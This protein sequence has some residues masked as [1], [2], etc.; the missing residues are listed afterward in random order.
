MKLSST[1]VA[2]AAALAGQTLAGKVSV[3]P[4][5]QVLNMLAEVKAKGTKMMDEE[6]G[7]FAKYAE[8]VDDQKAELGFN[9][10][11]A[12]SKI[13]ELVAFI[14]KAESDSAKAGR[15]VAALKAE[16][17][18]LSAERQSATR[19]RETEKAEYQKAST[20]LSES[21]D[22]LER[23]LQTLRTQASGDAE[24]ASMLQSMVAAKGMPRV[25][26][27]F[28]AERTA[29]AGASAQAASSSSSL[30]SDDEEGEPGAP[31]AAAYESQ[32][33]GVLE[34]L[35]GLLG[36][37]RSELENAEK[38]EVNQAHQ[39]ALT[40][41]HLS[42]AIARDQDEERT[43]KAL[44]G[45]HASASAKA[46]AELTET[47]RSKEAD[48]ALRAETMATFKA[49]SDAFQENQKTRKAELV[50]IDKATEILSSPAVA[51]SYA[52]HVNLAQ[53]ASRAVAPVA[54]ASKSSGSSRRNVAFLQLRSTH[55]QSLAASS[56]A[57]A[58]L[59]A[60]AQRLGSRTLARAASDMGGM[61]FDKVINMIEEMINKLK[62]DAAE[63][64]NHKSWC[65]EQLQANKEKRN[66]RSA[67]AERLEADVEGFEAD[68]ADKGDTIVQLS[69][70]Q[71]D[72]AKGMDEATSLRRVERAEHE[73]T[74]QDAASGS[75]AVHR[76]LVVLKEFYA[77]AGQASLLQQAPAMERYTGM[78]SG[79][80]GL[81]G[82]L[83]VIQSDFERL[84]HRTETSEETAL[85]EYKEFMKES[86]ASK[87][88]KHEAE[89]KLKLDKDEAEFQRG[90]TGKD[91]ASTQ[92]ELAKAK[93][94]YESLKP[95]CIEVH[96]SFE[97]RVARRKEEIEALK[98][99]YATL[100]QKSD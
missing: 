18:R 75:L 11:S 41:K 90:N 53:K 27:A 44:R 78:Q 65:D 98:E 17:E 10:K 30:R 55:R 2:A 21:V 82:M 49:K 33:G 77:S 25:L 31:Q 66:S 32:S 6:Q 100:G 23:A 93:E 20:D 42:S 91:L 9:V 45:K 86:S 68:I 94:Y 99:A 1:S 61:G 38:A 56:R 59:R 39:Y 67:Q 40:E 37:F 26:T 14:D 97:Q 76:A 71:A 8:W 5:Q 74:I 83:E 13:E 24:A 29:A 46:Q 87:Q 73:A 62:Q 7:M 16:V 50:A 63:E 72:L 28:L 80:G 52:E 54:P 92:K 4:T 15:R 70:E 47:R 12:A 35:E 19:V 88:Q 60:Q 43:Q 3:T 48:Q 22:A 95:S 58:L 89:V 36:K 79:K 96:V 34:M 81:I 69:Q 64:A 51:G 84:Q 57:A 85:V